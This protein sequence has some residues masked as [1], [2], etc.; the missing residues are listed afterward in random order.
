MEVNIQLH[1]RRLC[2]L[3]KSDRHIS[4]QGQTGAQAR[5]HSLD[6]RNNY[7]IFRKLNDGSSV[8]QPVTYSLHY[9]YV[10]APGNY[11]RLYYEFNLDINKQSGVLLNVNEIQTEKIHQQCWLYTALCGIWVFRW[12]FLVLSCKNRAILISLPPPHYKSSTSFHNRIWIPKLLFFKKMF[13]FQGRIQ[14]WRNTYC[15]LC[16]GYTVWEI[17]WTVC[18]WWESLWVHQT[19]GNMMGQV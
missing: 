8:I 13:L 7:C 1:S 2:F 12:R 3:E 5:L 17:S 9:R 14:V 10:I 4:V 15:L 19:S 11:V 6:E 18:W 16:K